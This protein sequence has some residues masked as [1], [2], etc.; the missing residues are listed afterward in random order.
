[1]NSSGQALFRR[2]RHHTSDDVQSDCSP[3]ELIEVGDFRIDLQTRSATLGGRELQLDDAEFDLLV[4]IASHPKQLVT[5]QT[6]LATRWPDRG[7]RQS[8][9]VRV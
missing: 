6:M 9:F 5:P 1:M 8:Q 7:S 4:F 2:S 3:C